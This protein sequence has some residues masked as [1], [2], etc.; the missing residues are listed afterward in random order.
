VLFGS[1]VCSRFGSGRY[2]LILSFSSCVQVFGDFLPSI[3][4]QSSWSSRVCF[5]VCAKGTLLLSGFG[6]RCSLSSASRSKPVFFTVS[7]KGVAAL[8]FLLVTIF[9]L[10]VSIPVRVFGSEL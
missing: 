6:F 2:G 3:S 8:Q 5:S 1:F 10:G 4:F 7:Q 9:Q